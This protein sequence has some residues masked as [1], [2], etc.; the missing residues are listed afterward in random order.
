MLRSTEPVPPDQREEFRSIFVEFFPRLRSFF[1]SCGF[2]PTDAE[3][4]SQTAL[5]TVYK[6]RGQFRGD[7]SFDAWVY[8]IARN[9]A[10][11]EWRRRGRAREEEPVSEA[12]PD[13]VPSAETRTTDRQDLRRAVDALAKLPAGMRACLLLHVQKGLSY[14][15][16]GQRLSL[17]VPTVKVQIWNARRRLRS[18]LEEQPP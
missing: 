1:H 9:V 16:I 13:D 12:I 10:R 7:G 14:R 2:Q 4:L 11:D 8:S 18:L 15:E 6:S 17:A 5:W 3:D